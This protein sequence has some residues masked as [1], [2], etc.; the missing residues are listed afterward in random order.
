M[1]SAEEIV[2]VVTESDGEGRRDG[3]G[4]GERDGESRRR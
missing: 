1:V 3:N 4:R 2:M